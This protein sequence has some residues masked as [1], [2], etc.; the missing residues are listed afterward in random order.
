MEPLEHSVPDVALVRGDCSFIRVTESDP[1]DHSGLGVTVHVDMDSLMMA[2]WDAGGTLRSTYRHRMD[3][4]RDAL[5]C[6]IR[7]SH[8]PVFPATGLKSFGGLGR[9][10]IIDLYAGEDDQV[11]RAAVPLPAENID[12]VTLSSMEVRVSTCGVT[13]YRHIKARLVSWNTEWDMLDVD[14]LMEAVA[15]DGQNMNEFYQRVISTDE[16][17][18][19]DSDDRDML[20]DFMDSDVWSVT[21]LDSY[22][23][24][25]DEEDCCDSDDRDMLEDF[26]D[27]DVWSVTDLDSYRSDVEEEDCC[28]SDD[29]DMLDDFMDS[30]I[31]SVTDIDSYRSD[32]DEEDHCDSDV[33]V[34]E[35]LNYLG[36]NCIMD[37]CAGG[38]LSLSESDLTGPNG[39]YVTDGPVGQIGTLSP[40]T[41]S[42]E[43]LV[44]PGGT[45]PSSDFAGMLL[46]AIPVD[47]IG[48]W[49][50]L[51]PSGSDSAGPDG[52][53]VTGGPVGQPGTLS[54]STF[55]S[56]ILVDPGGTFPSS[57]LAGMLLPA[58]PVHPVGIWGTLSSSDSDPAGRDGSHVTWD[59][60]PDYLRVRG[61]GGSWWDVP[62]VRPGWDEGSGC[63]GGV[64]SSEGPCW[65]CD[66]VGYVTSGRGCART[67]PDRVDRW[68]VARVAV[69][70]P[71]VWD[72][73]FAL[74]PVEELKKTGKEV[75]GRRLD[76]RDGWSGSAV[77]GISAV[78]A[79]VVMYAVLLNIGALS[80][81]AVGCPA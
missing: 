8:M 63:S 38:M 24:D 11:L 12:R 66:V 43:I 81:R 16:E 79:R 75:V 18:C 74:S 57:D 69:P 44:D 28:D 33:A 22:R 42:S 32:V 7:F 50:T 58:I 68:S 65:P 64:A 55:V 76:V 25:V 62:L 49:G 2:P 9:T 20:D 31:W 41:S 52:P 51:P 14:S 71:A 61:T 67:V 78:V 37:V 5:C 60:A 6:V 35:G 29:R 26:M 27:S 72:P 21:D 23:S 77:A 56:A 73:L 54:P 19:C 30:D 13:T 1:L 3:I 70:L 40:S 4:W 15:A 39:P 45:L 36:R 80:D 59:V 53:S 48:Q 17:D 46:P 34:L 47:P 10:C